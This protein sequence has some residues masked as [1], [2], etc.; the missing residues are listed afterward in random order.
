MAKPRQEMK[1]RIMQ[2]AVSADTRHTLVEMMERKRHLTHLENIN[3]ILILLNCVM[4]LVFLWW[5]F[6]LSRMGQGDILGMLQLAVT[7]T[8][9]VVFIVIALTLF[10]YTGKVTK[11]R[12]KEDD[13]FEDL[14]AEVVERL[15]ASWQ[16]ESDSKLRDEV[17]ALM[18]ESDIN[19]RYI[20]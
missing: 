14:R 5:L 11:D 8:P 6:Q 16:I 4:I 3:K 12:K 18:E 13:E 7:S 10:A 2:L 1:A 15:E 17:S 19:L 20:H 9:V